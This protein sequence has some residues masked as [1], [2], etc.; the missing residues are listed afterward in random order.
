MRKERWVAWLLIVPVAIT[1]FSAKLQV[2]YT[3]EAEADRVAYLESVYKDADAISEWANAA[4]GRASQNG[5][6]TGSN[7][8]F[9][10]GAAVT[11]AEFAKMLAAVMKLDTVG[12]KESSLTDVTQRDWFYPYVTA[13]YQAG[14]MS[15][16]NGTFNPRD[17]ITREQ[18]ASTLVRALALAPAKPAAAIKDMNQA[19]AWAK[20]AIETAVASGLIVGDSSGFRPQA[21]VTREMAAVVAMRAYDFVLINKPGDPA[22]TGSAM[23]EAVVKQMA[24]TAAFMQNAVKD[25]AVSSIGGDWTVLALARSGLNVPQAYYNKYYANVEATLKEKSGKLHS[26]K[27]TEYDRVILALTAI[28]K[29]VDNVAGYDLLEPLA[30]FDTLIKQGINGPIFALLALDSK[31]YEIPAAAGVKTQTTRELLVEFIL[32]REVKGGGWA[33]GA[34]PSAADPD[35]TAMAL[36]SLTPYYASDESVKTAVERGIAWLS[37]A[38]REDGGFAIGDAANSE[39]I[40]QVIVALTGLGINPHQDARFVKQG[41]SALQ[42]LLGYAA[43]NGG[44]YHIKQGGADNGGAAPGEV[45]LMA[46]DQAL[47][48]LAAYKRFIEKQPSLYDMSDVS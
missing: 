19:A 40:A 6:V 41:H 36:Q 4:I 48:A 25:P 44:F 3:A 15:G 45:D 27:Y 9:N 47:Y 46:S 43:P 30:D 12:I 11:R 1:L 5:F 32:N 35:I 10:P 7:G 37:N 26:V 33:L 22:E 16:Y 14:Y 17:N 39:S 38:Q 42:A 31:D 2:A 13:V 8:R 28:G 20:S 21:T 18:L 23:D 34:N 29:S 24:S